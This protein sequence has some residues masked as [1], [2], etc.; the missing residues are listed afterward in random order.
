MNFLIGNLLK[1]FFY[2]QNRKIGLNKE[3]SFQ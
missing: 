2:I 1:Q 3:I